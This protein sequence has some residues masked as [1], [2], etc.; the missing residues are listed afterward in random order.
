[1]SWSASPNDDRS[2][3]RRK[4]Q[5]RGP[6]WVTDHAR[7]I[8]DQ[9]A[10]PP[11]PPPVTRRAPEPPRSSPAGRRW[12]PPRVPPEPTRQFDQ[13]R[14]VEPPRQRHDPPTDRHGQGRAGA[15]PRSSDR[16]PDSRHPDSRHPDSRYPDDRTDGG[17]G[18]GDNGRYDADSRSGRSGPGYDSGSGDSR[19]DDGYADSRYDDGSHA[20]NAR[21][22][23]GGRYDDHDA[24]DRRHAG[25]RR[26]ADDHDHGD[27]DGDDHGD[28][29][30]R[31]RAGRTG[32]PDDHD[33]RDDG[34]EPRH[35]RDR[36]TRRAE[37]PQQQHQGRGQDADTGPR[38]LT[39]TRVAAWRSRQLTQQGLAAFRR[40][41]TADGADRSG[42]T[43]LTY[44][45][46]I[47]YGADAAI[48]VA[49]ANTLF[50]S[51]ATAESKTK[52]ALYLLI[53]VA[54]FALIAP[55]IGPLLDRLQ[56]GRRV[57][58]AASFVGRAL[59]AVV[60]AQHYD[61]WLLYPA[62]LGAMVLSRSFN[63]LKAAVTPRLLPPDI[64]LTKVNSRLAMFGLAAGAVIGAGAAG[65]A[66]LFS[67]GGALLFTAAVCLV[68]AWLCLRIPA[69]VEVT[70]G[71]VPASL[72]GGS[73]DRG[74]DRGGGGRGWDDQ[75]ERGHDRGGR[76][77]DRD[78][79]DDAD[80]SPPADT[81]GRRRRE[82]LGRHVIVAL[83]GNGTIRV[84]TGFLT[85]FVAFVVKEQ[86]G[87]SAWQQVLL[88]GMVGLGAGVGSMA[89]NAIGAR[90]HFTKPDQVILTC[91]SVVLG[92]AVLAALIDGIATVVLV[93]LVSGVCSALAKVCQ[94]AVIQNDMS[95]ES[96]ASAFG[97]TETILQ[98][99]WT[100][101]GALGVLLPPTYW[102]G[103]AVVSVVL[104]L[105]T[106]Q[107]VLTHRGG[108]L[109]PSLGGDRPA[110][111]VRFTQRE[112]R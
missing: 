103:F 84:L 57:A 88:L 3:G 25:S 30:R 60:M 95:E 6:R 110:R 55:V 16:H 63:L 43:A 50:F 62:A 33:D 90:Q 65:F 75:G 83:W 112:N 12:T 36:S 58:L 14:R 70:E 7:E 28:R 68:G 97:R 17:R 74:G 44:P 26:Y 13:T 107:T 34:R 99:S 67:S 66:V 91:V 89:G 5:R 96:R 78:E 77:D 87:Q 82:P 104:A 98:L 48:A 76:A 20:D 35:P 69:W 81:A 23:K 61:D 100:F 40:A 38:K 92:V 47:N 51:A 31:G 106:A 41:A 24:D 111:T 8:A 1:M 53:T 79:G 22:G 29:T 93:A 94:D 18:R 56:R 64:T 73:G 9:Q 4:R 11:P 105:G 109:I 15:A 27:R 32:R 46:M 39:V 59:L 42:L 21:Y 37:Q 102:L 85:L 80:R 45:T 86:S 52:V 54:P 10:P 101:G 19:Y 72:R 71:E 49:L 2:G 108:S